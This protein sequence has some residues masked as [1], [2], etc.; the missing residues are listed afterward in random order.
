M[1]SPEVSARCPTAP[2]SETVRMPMRTLF[3]GVVRHERHR[4][5]LRRHP[6]TPHAVPDPVPGL[7]LLPR[8]HGGPDPPLPPGGPAAPRP[9]APW[10]PVPDSSCPRRPPP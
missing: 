10:L 9:T 5:S 6:L 3:L 4:D 2:K 7:G 8:R 1:A